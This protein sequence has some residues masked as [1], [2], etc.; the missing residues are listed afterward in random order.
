MFPDGTLRV[1]N[2]NAGSPPTLTNIVGGTLVSG[3][4]LSGSVPLN[5]LSSTGFNPAD[6]T[7]S[8]WSRVRVNP[9]VDGANSEVADLLAGSGMLRA[10]PEPQSW[11][12]MLIGFASIGSAMRFRRAR[13]VHA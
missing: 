4:S 10:V 3:N 5:L 13:A 2:F 12:M 8:L 1:V 6:Y 9:A 7:F 11:A